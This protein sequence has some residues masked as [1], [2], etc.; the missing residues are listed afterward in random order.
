M[1]TGGRLRGD[2]QK[3]AWIGVG[4]HA[5]MARG[6]TVSRRCSHSYHQDDTPP[7]PLFPTSIILSH[8]SSLYSLPSVFLPYWC[9]EIV[10]Q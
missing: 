10:Q 8:R 5:E 4:G 3:A 6:P 1:E 7:P 2:R 9:P